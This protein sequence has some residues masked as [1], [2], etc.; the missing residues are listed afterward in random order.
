MEYHENGQISLKR[1]YKNGQLHGLQERYYDNGQLSSKGNYK[2]GEP[3]GP[4]EEFD[5]NG[6]LIKTEWKNGELIK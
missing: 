5:E 4:W 3:D 1:N 2:D 6:N